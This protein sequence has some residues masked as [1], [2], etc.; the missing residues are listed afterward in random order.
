MDKLQIAVLSII[1][2]A[3]KNENSK[4]PEDFNFDKVFSIAKKHQITVMVYYGLLNCGVD[5]GYPVMQQL[6]M[7]TCQNVAISEQQMYAL[8]KIFSSFD[9][10]QIDYMPLKG[11]LLKEMYPKP[12][13][14]SMGD[15]DILIKE[16]QYKSIKPIMEELGYAEKIESNHELIWTK[17]GSYIELHKR[18][19]PSYNKDYFAYYGDGWR[20]A[21][22]KNGTRFSMT[23]EDQMIYLFTHFAKHYRDAG[24][25]LRHIVDLWVYRNA[26]PDLDEEYIKAELQKLRLYDFYVNIVKTLDVWFDGGESNEITDFIT[27]V[28]FSSGVYGRNETQV[29][30][31]AVKISKT[32]GKSKNVK[33]R[34]YLKLIFPPVSSLKQKYTFLGKAP[35]LLPVMWVVRIF[36]VLLFKRERIKYNQY[37]VNTMNQENIDSYQKSLDLVGLDFNFKE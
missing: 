29:L 26:K 6:F 33:K 35:F 32:Y 4:L 34:K 8:R 7:F 12:E 19:I 14:R 37:I 30:S 11:T 16:E 36:T 31:E 22:N 25:G 21:K 9:E 13:M 10:N 24:I 1:K 15:A 28:I 3:L 18:L 20:L 27:N 23:D 17:K 2:S 5:Q